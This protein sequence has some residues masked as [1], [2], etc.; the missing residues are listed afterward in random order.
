M[1]KT[2]KIE[3]PKIK[4]ARL[5][6]SVK[7]DIRKYIKRERRRELPKGEDFWDFDCKFG[8]T[9]AEAK[10]CHL[11]E[12]SGCIDE[13]EKE[14]LT[15][16]YVE[17]LV[18]AARRTKKPIVEATRAIDTVRGMTLKNFPIVPGSIIRGR[19]AA[20]VVRVAAITGN[21]T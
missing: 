5:F 19:K 2:F 20:T 14:Q 1:K 4:V 17:I 10:E 15:S 12:I 9:E 16:F 13:A 3:H 21:T 7:S 6:E 11:A 8:A 18:K